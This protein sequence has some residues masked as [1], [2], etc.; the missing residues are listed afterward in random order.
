MAAQHRRPLSGM[1]EED[2]KTSGVLGSHSFG[3]MRFERSVL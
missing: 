3:R 2:P 1:G